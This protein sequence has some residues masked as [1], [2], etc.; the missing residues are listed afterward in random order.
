M[1]ASEPIVARVRRLLANAGRPSL[2]EAEAAALKAQELLQ[3]HHLDES[4]AAVATSEDDI[5]IEIESCDY[6]AKV[7][8]WQRDLGFAVARG[9]FCKAVHTPRG[10]GTDCR[11]WLHFVGRSEDIEAALALYEY[12]RRE[13]KRLAREAFV[14]HLGW[15]KEQHQIGVKAVRVKAFYLGDERVIP[16]PDLK[17]DPVEWKESFYNGAVWGLD[18]R[19]RERQRV[20]AAQHPVAGAIARVT[21]DAIDRKIAAFFEPV[22]VSPMGEP[23]RAFSGWVAGLQAARNVELHERKSVE[24][25]ARRSA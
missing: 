23:I 8:D 16:P 7:I 5:E 17:P 22:R 19:L 4:A 2:Y 11:S 25:G 14:T 24:G 21:G 3:A 1:N 20:F 15:A 13:L 9:C 10:A 12:L 6:A 18:G